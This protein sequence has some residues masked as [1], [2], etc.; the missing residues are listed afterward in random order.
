M[1]RQRTGGD[2]GI[3]AGATSGNVTVNSTGDITAGKSDG[4]LRDGALFRWRWPKST[5]R[6]VTIHWGHCR[7]D[8]EGI[9]AEVEDGVGDLTV[10]STG[11]IEAGG[12]GVFAEIDDGYGTYHSYEHGQHQRGR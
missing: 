10:T 2:D 7:G 1:V 6:T 4:D 12:F 11:N 9:E 5:Q 8:D 3:D